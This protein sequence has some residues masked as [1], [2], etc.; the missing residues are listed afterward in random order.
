MLPTREELA[1]V[2]V[3]EDDE[4]TLELLCDNLTADRY[5]TLPAPGAGDALRLCHYKAPDLLILD[6]GLPDAAGL[7]VLREIRS[8]N[9]AT[10]RYDPKLP[11]LILSGRGS[12]EDRVRGLDAGGDDYM[13]K[14]VHYP[15]LLGGRQ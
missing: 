7:D 10:G 13:V 3:C 14:P 15:E 1:T 5:L 11:V 4:A 2:V 6:L 8:A 9:G 12:V